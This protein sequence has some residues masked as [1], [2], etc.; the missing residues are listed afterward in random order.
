[1]T[2]KNSKLVYSTNPDI[3][4]GGGKQNS[5]GPQNKT[6]PQVLRIFLD[7][8]GRKGK[9]VTVVEGFSVNPQHLSEI[10]R[11]LKQ[12]LGTGGTAKQGRI[13]IHGDFRQKI[14]E[15]LNSMGYKNKIIGG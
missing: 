12:L 8:K 11:T 9:S 14:S 10:A 5:A 3:K 13:E 6:Q 7:K 1:M 2:N 4:P 15:K